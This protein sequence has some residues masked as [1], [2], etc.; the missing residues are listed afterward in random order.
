MGLL[1]DLFLGNLDASLV[2]GVVS[3]YLPLSSLSPASQAQ[4]DLLNL[5]LYILCYAIVLP[6]QKSGFRS[7]SPIVDPEALLRNIG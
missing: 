3:T 6:G 4:R 2:S 1:L 5:G 7:G